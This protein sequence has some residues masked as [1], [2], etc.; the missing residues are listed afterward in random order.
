MTAPNF[1]T[2]ATEFR[3]IM[4]LV[5]R[6]EKIAA[7]AGRSIDRMELSMDLSAAHNSCPLKL[8]QLAQASDADLAHDVFGIAR[9]IDRDTGRLGGCFL[10]R[11]ADVKLAKTA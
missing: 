2:S 10:P 8:E 6:A 9:H 1:K 11:F 4:T 7:S 5:D 3:L